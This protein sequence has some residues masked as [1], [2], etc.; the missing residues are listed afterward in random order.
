[1]KSKNST[2]WKTRF[3]LKPI[4]FTEILYMAQKL[5]A[6]SIHLS[7]SPNLVKVVRMDFLYLH[8]K[9]NTIYLQ[10]RKLRGVNRVSN[11]NCG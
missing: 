7:C 6:T 3:I 4:Q 10:F 1:M 2:K 5:H 11:C 9:D 8:Y